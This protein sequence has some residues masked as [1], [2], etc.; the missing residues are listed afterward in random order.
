M[1]ARAALYAILAF[2]GISLMANAPGILVGYGLVYAAMYYAV[3]AFPPAMAAALFATAHA[4]ALAVIAETRAAF[5]LVPAASL[6]LRT[7]LVYVAARLRGRLGAL[8]EAFL[9]AGVDQLVALTIAILYYGNDGIHAGLAIY[10]LL[11]APYAYYAYHYTTLEARRHGW[12]P[13]LGLTASLAGLAAYYFG[14]Y[15]FLSLPSLAAGAVAAL[16]LGAAV[17]RPHGA[18]ALGAAALALAV[19]ASGLALGGTPL[20]YNLKVSLYPFEPHSWGP[21]RWAQS[22]TGPCQ[23][24]SNVFRYTHDPARLRIVEGCVTVTGRVVGAPKIEDDG[25]YCFDVKIINSS[26]AI[27]SLGNEVLRRGALHVEVV[28]H[29]HFRVLGPIGGG[30]CPG[31]IVRVTGVYVVDTDHGMWAEVHPA[32]NITV[33]KRA[34]TSPWPDCLRG[35]AVGGG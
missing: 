34:S 5:T 12:A 33:L 26:G 13:A 14:A 15:A 24:T 17:A 30:V 29:D 27:L 23:S 4:A 9:L 6:A 3:L 25:D 20:S 10:E 32:Y 7:P 16:A 2:A 31:D 19:A 11:L 35:R 8:G 22:S 28:P 18:T 21:Q 1:K